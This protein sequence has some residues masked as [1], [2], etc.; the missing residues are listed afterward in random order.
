[1]S[2]K[3]DFWS[4]VTQPSIVR[5]RLSQSQSVGLEPGIIGGSEWSPTV[6]PVLAVISG[7]KVKEACSRQMEW[8]KVSAFARP[9]LQASTC[10]PSA[11]MSCSPVARS[12]HTHPHGQHL[13]K[14]STRTVWP[15][16]L[17]KTD[18]KL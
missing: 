14:P 9:L 11:A 1:M 18:R 16:A 6:G 7:C 12:T 3:G 17:R 15:S 13:L 2:P 10:V 4:P 8:V 5:G